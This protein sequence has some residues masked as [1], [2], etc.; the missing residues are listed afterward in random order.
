MASYVKELMVKELEKNFED[1]PYVFISTFADAT[2]EEAGEL[3]NR[4][5]KC[6]NSAMVAK[7]TLV[8]RVLASTECADA[9]EL[10]KGQVF[11]AFG[12]KDPQLVSK[13]LVD[14]GSQNKKF[15][16]CGV[17]FEKKVCDES[18]VKQL[19]TLPSRE[20]LLT[21]VVVRVKSPITGFVMTLGQLGRGLV[22]VINEIKKQREAGTAGA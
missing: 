10:I 15:V 22:Q 18:F 8:K 13:T 7:Q 17:I 12:D 2:V 4:L 16:P 14:Y 1:N 19:A 3:R 11:L 20:E 6:S 21:Q 5:R 9:E